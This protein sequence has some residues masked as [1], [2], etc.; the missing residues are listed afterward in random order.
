MGK[1]NGV[2]D[3]RN[4]SEIINKIPN[5]ITMWILK[6]KNIIKRLVGMLFILSIDR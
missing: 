3:D 6:Y 1:I 5:T 4:I 2:V